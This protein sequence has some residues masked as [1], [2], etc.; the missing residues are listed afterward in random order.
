MNLDHPVLSSLLP[1]VLLIFIGFVAGRAKLV[2]GV[3]GDAEY[4]RQTAWQ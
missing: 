2:R 3:F 4:K 1:V